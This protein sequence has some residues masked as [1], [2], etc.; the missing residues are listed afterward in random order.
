ML[1]DLRIRPLIDE[2]SI[3]AVDDQL[4][5]GPDCRGDRDAAELLS[6]GDDQWRPFPAG[7]HDEDIAPGQEL[8]QL[9][10]A[11]HRGTNVDNRAL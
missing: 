6:L 2:Q 3:F 7:R 4:A 11:E 1:D 5:D 8:R 9:F 10:A